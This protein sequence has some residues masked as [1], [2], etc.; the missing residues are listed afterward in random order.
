MLSE[1]ERTGRPASFQGEEI[2][3]FP[4]PAGLYGYV[5]VFGQVVTAG[6]HI[7]RGRFVDIN[8]FIVRKLADKF[9]RGIAGKTAAVHKDFVPVA[10]NNTFVKILGVF[11]V[12]GG[13]QERTCR[14]NPVSDQIG[15]NDAGCVIRQT[16]KQPVV[17]EDVSLQIL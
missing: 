12:I 4:D 6:P 11:A 15:K 1:H 7:V 3:P 17:G 10:G 9:F 14:D 5:F 13:F 8:M 2:L 16:G